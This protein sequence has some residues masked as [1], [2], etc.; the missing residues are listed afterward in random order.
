MTAGIESVGIA[1]EGISGNRILHDPPLPT[2]PGSGPNALAR[3]GRDVLEQPGAKYMI[4]MLGINDIGQ[5]GSSSAPL[6]ESVTADDVIA[7][8]QQLADRAHEMGLKVYGATLTPFSV[9]TSAGY[10]TPDKEVIRQAVNTWIRNGTA[11]DAVIDFDLVLR[12]PANPIQFLAAYD[13]GDHL[14]P[15]DLGY[16]VMAAAIDLTLFRPGPTQ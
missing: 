13:S 9:Y 6:S 8:L 1:N 12:D 5:P 3:F 4:V 2:S 10:F 7:A 15:N 16:S 14:H 11:Y